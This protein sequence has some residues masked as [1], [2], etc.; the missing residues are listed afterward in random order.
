VRLP[1]QSASSM[2]GAWRATRRQVGAREVYEF[3]IVSARYHTIRIWP[4]Q[5]LRS[6]KF[7]VLAKKLALT[8]TAAVE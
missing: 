6:P 8:G 3:D 4:Y 5:H 1:P 7:T 2:G